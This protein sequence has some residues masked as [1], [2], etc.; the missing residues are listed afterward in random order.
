M[1]SVRTTLRAVHRAGALQVGGVPGPGSV[2]GV[3]LLFG[4]AAVVEDYWFCCHMLK[5]REV[6][7]G[8][9]GTWPF[10]HHALSSRRAAPPPAF[11]AGG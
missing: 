7:R 1:L 6:R 2:V 10:A 4:A 8:P 5:S 9:L 3:G 11:T